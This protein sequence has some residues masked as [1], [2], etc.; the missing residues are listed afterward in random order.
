MPGFESNLGQAFQRIAFFP[1]ILRSVR[2]GVAIMAKVN[3]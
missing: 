1:V 2:S 3:P